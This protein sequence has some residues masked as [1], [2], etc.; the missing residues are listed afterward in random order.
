MLSELVLRFLLWT[1]LVLRSVNELF[2][3]DM[4][5]IDEE[6]RDQTSEAVDDEVAEEQEELTVFLN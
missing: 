6:S 5:F 2:S 3:R 1:E 4:H